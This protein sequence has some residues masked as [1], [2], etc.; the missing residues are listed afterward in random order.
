[1]DD[2]GRNDLL[3]GLLVVD[4]LLRS[5]D[6]RTGF[7]PME[8]KGASKSRSHRKQGRICGTRARRLVTVGG[9]PAC[10]VTSRCDGAE[11]KDI[12]LGRNLHFFRVRDFLLS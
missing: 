6:M 9:D 11:G 12:G 8:G 7:T 10:N 3:S 2:L 4:S 5:G 1:M